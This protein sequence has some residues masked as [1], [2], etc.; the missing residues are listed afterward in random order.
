MLFK[1]FIKIFDKLKS[2]VLLLIC[3]FTYLYSFIIVINIKY[4]NKLWGII[5]QKYSKIKIIN[6]ED[7]YFFNILI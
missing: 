1:L 4:S 7:I 2:F 3:I 5:K 6:K